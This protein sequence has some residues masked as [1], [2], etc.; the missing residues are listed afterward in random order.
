MLFPFRV[1]H[2]ARFGELAVHGGSQRQVVRRMGFDGQFQVLAQQRL[3]LRC[4]AVVDNAM[5]ALYRTL[6]AQVGNTLFRNDYLHGVFRVVKVRHHRYER[7]DCPTLGGARC[8][9]DTDI[10]VAG[11]IAATADTVHH[12]RTEY[13]GRIDI[14]I[15]VGFQSGVDGNQTETACHFGIVRNLLRTEHNLVV[16]EIHVV[17]NVLQLVC[18]YGK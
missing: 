8:G 4:N 18:T 16:E 13:V 7:R 11:E 3:V 9:E 15:N 5:G 14:A 17:D 6:A 10:S 1:E 2:I 12:L